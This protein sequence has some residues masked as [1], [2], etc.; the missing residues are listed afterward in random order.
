MVT[1]TA[2][3]EFIALSEATREI[4]FL[5]DLVQDLDI[6]QEFSP[7]IVFGDNQAALT[8]AKDSLAAKKRFRHLAAHRAYVQQNVRDGLVKFEYV[9]TKDNLAD[10]FTKGLAKPRL[11]ELRAR[12]LGHEKQEIVYL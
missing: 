10:L 5:R 8:N 3:S 2:A 9:Q 7:T 4:A 6:R 1:S 11:S 12:V